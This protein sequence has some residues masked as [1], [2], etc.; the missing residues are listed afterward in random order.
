M[1]SPEQNIAETTPAFIANQFRSLSIADQSILDDVFNRAG[2][3]PAETMLTREDLHE[4]VS[5]EQMLEIRHTL[6]ELS[7]V[8]DPES[9]RKLAK[10][11]SDILE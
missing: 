2:N 4:L 8:Q 3:L 11:I 1:K 10:I 7:A 9:K 6:N 5:P